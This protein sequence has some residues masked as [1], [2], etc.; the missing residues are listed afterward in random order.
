MTYA[1]ALL[2]LVA[3]VLWECWRTP[4]MPADY[5]PDPKGERN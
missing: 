4:E 1:A 3:W 2:A 5:D